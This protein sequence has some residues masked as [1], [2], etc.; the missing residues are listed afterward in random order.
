MSRSSPQN[1]E[2]LQAACADAVGIGTN[3]PRYLSC[4]EQ[5]EARE[6]QRQ[7]VDMICGQS[8]RY[9]E[10]A[11]P[12]SVAKARRRIEKRCR[13]QIAREKRAGFGPALILLS[14]VISWIL[15]RAFDWLWGWY[16]G[17]PQSVAAICQSMPQ[18]V[19]WEEDD[20]SDDE[21]DREASY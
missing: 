8:V 12:A 14:P 9:F 2:E 4:T 10:H 20:D 17:N 7:L 15:G 5:R 19:V 1:L 13:K 18:S 6:A 16:R 3:E 21:E 11:K